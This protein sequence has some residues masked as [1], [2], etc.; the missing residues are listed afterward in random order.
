MIEWA[1]RQINPFTGNGLSTVWQQAGIWAGLTAFVGGTVALSGA[2]AAA[3]EPV[4]AGV[5]VISSLFSPKI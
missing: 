2:F 3:A 5:N 4:S 1:K